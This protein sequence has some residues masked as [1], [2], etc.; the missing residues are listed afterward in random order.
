RRG[1]GGA[2]GCRRSRSARPAWRPCGIPGII[3]Q[4]RPVALAFV[5]LARVAVRRVELARLEGPDVLA[6]LLDMVDVDVPRIGRR[7]IATGRGPLAAARRIGVAVEIAVADVGAARVGRA[8]LVR[9]L[10]GASIEPEAVRVVREAVRALHVAAGIAAAARPERL[11]AVPAAGPAIAAGGKIVGSEGA[12]RHGTSLPLDVS[13]GGWMDARDVGSQRTTS[14]GAGSSVSPET[15][16]VGPAASRATSSAYAP[17]SSSRV[18][19]ESRTS[20]WSTS[21]VICEPSS[22]GSSASACITRA[23]TARSLASA[24]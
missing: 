19:P 14:A 7:G 5:E 16:T 6:I 20:P 13:H 10:V 24:A 15:A 1:H 3:L 4:I 8:A 2:A 21:T 11:G 9:I 12:G 18:V 23:A 17:C 22:A